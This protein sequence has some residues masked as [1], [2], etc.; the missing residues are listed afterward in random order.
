MAKY[1]NTGISAALRPNTANVASR[2]FEIEDGAFETTIKDFIDGLYGKD[3]KKALCGRAISDYVYD[4]KFGTYNPETDTYKRFDLVDLYKDVRKSVD[5]D[6]LSIYAVGA[7]FGMFGLWYGDNP[8]SGTTL[9]A[10]N[11]YQAHDILSFDNYLKRSYVTF[12]GD[13]K[14][15]LHN[16]QND[17][18]VVYERYIPSDEELTNIV[19]SLKDKGVEFTEYE[20]GAKALAIKTNYAKLNKQGDKITGANSFLISNIPFVGSPSYMPYGGDAYRYT[21]AYA[22]FDSSKSSEKAIRLGIVPSLI[23]QGKIHLVGTGDA[24]AYAGMYSNPNFGKMDVANKTNKYPTGYKTLDVHLV[25]SDMNYAILAD[26]YYVKKFTTQEFNWTDKTGY[27]QKATITEIKNLA[28]TELEEDTG[29]NKNP[30]YNPNGVDTDTEMSEL[31]FHREEDKAYL[32]FYA[33]PENTET[34]A[35][36]EE[37]AVYEITT[38]GDISELCLVFNEYP[39]RYDTSYSYNPETLTT[40][41][42]LPTA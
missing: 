30:V 5:S 35:P 19:N 40:R 29:F 8:L 3:E 11:G 27:V 42:I 39:H 36:K 20:P 2:V 14:H 16:D 26:E 18:S 25:R 17:E 6:E 34:T 7:S 13:E 10:Y 15:L 32:R 33:R 28:N 23:E 38:T 12:R 9:S 41:L 1:Y 22:V 37:Y 21:N 31:V 4:V 24:I